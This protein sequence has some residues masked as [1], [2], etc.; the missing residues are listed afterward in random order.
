MFTFYVLCA[1]FS[2]SFAI[3]VGLRTGWYFCDN[4]DVFADALLSLWR[5]TLGR[6][7]HKKP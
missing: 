5:H 7:F 3:V 2:I 1:V 6:L 4:F